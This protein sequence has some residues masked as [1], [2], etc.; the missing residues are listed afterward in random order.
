[1]ASIILTSV[2]ITHLDNLSLLRGK[3]EKIKLFFNILSVPPY[4]PAALRSAAL[5]CAALR[6][7]A[8][9][10]PGGKGR[11]FYFRTSALG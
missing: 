8:L 11:I 10:A 3:E 4:P 1:M 6:C 5:R 2:G 9:R 7:A